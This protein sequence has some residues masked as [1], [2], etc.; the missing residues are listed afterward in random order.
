MRRLLAA[1]VAAPALVLA[2]AAWAQPY[3]PPAYPPDSY[4]QGYDPDDAG[5]YDPPAEPDY[6]QPYADPDD[7]MD[8]DDMGPGDMGSDDYGPPPDDQ[9]YAPYA[10]ADDPDDYRAPGDEGAPQYPPY[11]RVPPSPRAPDPP[12][13]SSQPPQSMTPPMGPSYEAG[14]PADLLDREDRLE[15]RIR[16]GGERGIV[17]PFHVDNLLVQLDS[18]RAQ[19]DE[20]A[21][22]DGGLNQTTRT[23]I[24]SR[25]ER[26]ERNVTW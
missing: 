26:L 19:Q 17:P 8:P 24:E 18:I 7:S 10:G 20:L 16:S 9:G 23:F 22:R 5:A 1:S 6:S 4:D 12:A 2:A 25:L 15:R 21:A 14:V 3:D 11:E 13:Y